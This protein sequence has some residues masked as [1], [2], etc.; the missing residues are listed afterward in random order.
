MGISTRTFCL[1]QSTRW[2]H[3][4]NVRGA[5]FIGT[6]PLSVGWWLAMLTSCWDDWL[7]GLHYLSGWSFDLSQFDPICVIWAPI[8]PSFEAQCHKPDETSLYFPS[9]LV[10]VPLLV[11]R[12][13]IPRASHANSHGFPQS[14]WSW[15]QTMV[16]CFLGMILIGMFIVPFVWEKSRSSPHLDPYIPHR[17]PNSRPPY[18]RRTRHTSQSMAKARAQR[19]SA[20]ARAK[21]AH[22]SRSATTMDDSPWLWLW[23]ILHGHWN[24]GFHIKSTSNT[25][26]MLLPVVNGQESYDML[27]RIRRLGRSEHTNTCCGFSVAWW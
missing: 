14:F 23:S 16:P 19:H 17:L 10:N 15:I 11:G 13:L 2:I 6:R 25:V 27:W 5:C 1:P 18:R 26:R 9:S 3:L 21:R 22:G 7:L 20:Q 8:F 12:K 4:V 24:L